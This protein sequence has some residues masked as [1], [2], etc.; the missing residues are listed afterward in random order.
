MDLNTDR[1]P[2]LRH[3]I[4]GLLKTCPV[5]LRIEYMSRFK[6]R[7]MPDIYVLVDAAT[8]LHS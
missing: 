7:K 4:F 6:L 8:R 1:K 2:M 3:K 5:Q